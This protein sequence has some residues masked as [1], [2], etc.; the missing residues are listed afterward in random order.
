MNILNLKKV[1]TT[2]EKNLKSIK[3]LNIDLSNY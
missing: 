3:V 1:T 2:S